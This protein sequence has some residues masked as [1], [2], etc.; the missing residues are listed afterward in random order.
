M[1]NLDVIL[2]NV[3]KRDG[4]GKISIFRLMKLEAAS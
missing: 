1:T 3:T 4:K 2:L